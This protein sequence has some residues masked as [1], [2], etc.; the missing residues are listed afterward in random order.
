MKEVA[1]DLPKHYPPVEPEDFVSGEIRSQVDSGL[2][3]DSGFGRQGQQFGL[4]DCM[5]GKAGAAGEQRFALSWRKVKLLNKQIINYI[6]WDHFQDIRPINRRKMCWDVNSY[7]EEAPV[8]V[9]DCHGQ[10]IQEIFSPIISG[11]KKYILL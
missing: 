6:A 2:C 9:Y 11:D 4:S 8:T 1:F 5:K 10:V 7:Q 3:V